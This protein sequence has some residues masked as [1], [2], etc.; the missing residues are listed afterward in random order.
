MTN[1]VQNITTFYAYARGGKMTKLEL[2]SLF[3]ASCGYCAALRDTGLKPGDARFNDASQCN[4][5]IQR[6][7][8]ER[9]GVAPQGWRSMENV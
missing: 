7:A 4:M 1:P 5:E 2:S 3:Y 6:V 9:W 8:R